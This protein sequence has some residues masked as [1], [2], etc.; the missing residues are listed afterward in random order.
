MTKVEAI[1]GRE[2]PVDPNNPDAKLAKVGVSVPE[3]VPVTDSDPEE[4]DKTP[5]RAF[6]RLLGGPLPARELTVDSDCGELD[7]T[8]NI[9]L[10]VE[11]RFP[12]TDWLGMIDAVGAGELESEVTESPELGGRPPPRPVPEDVSGP[13]VGVP[14][15][16]S[17]LADS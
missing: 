1:C 14:R 12:L 7:D 8:V 17:M 13:G 5:D 9:L 2:T 3:A 11:I 16:E 4:L 6:C 15:L 10:R